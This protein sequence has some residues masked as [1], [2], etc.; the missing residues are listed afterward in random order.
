MTA[1]MGDTVTEV[2]KTNDP[3]VIKRSR[4]TFKGKF[5]RVA[6][7]LVKELMRNDEGEFLFDQIIDLQVDA[8]LSDLH[9]V[10]EIVENLHFKY[11]ITRVHK[12]GSTENQLEQEDEQYASSL[13]KIY[14]DAFKVYNAY[15]SQ[16]QVQEKLN[17]NH[18]ALEIK[19]TQYQEKLGHF[20]A[21]A[22]EY[23]SAYNEALRVVISEDEFINR[24]APLQKSLLCKEYEGL[25]S[26][27]QELLAL[28]PQVEVVNESDKK[29]LFDC[30]K[31]K[32]NHRKTLTSLESLIKKFEV[33]D[34]INLAKLSPSPFLSTE[35]SSD[36]SGGCV[37]DSN[38][39]KIKLSAPKFSGKSRDFAVFKRDFKSIVMVD[40]RSAVEIGALLK[41]SVPPHYKYLLDKFELSEHEEMMNCLTEKFGR[42][43]IIVD[44]C[45]SELKRMK[46]LT[47]D[48]EFIKFVNHLEKLKCDL[49]QLG[50]L[51]EVA[52]TTV[53]T[54][55]ESKLPY[56]VHRDWIKLVSSEDM[57]K[58]PSSE[59]L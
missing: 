11:T 13:E 33:E 27:E 47:C 31:E 21:K 12:E 54:E 6:N 7:A 2:L 41:E 9:K 4:A 3:E 22:A 52:N 14:W 45:T 35:S 16:V 55:I 56:L 20:K 19:C 15:S 10:K 40:K 18:K 51:A 59:I 53:L 48:S 57:S 8:L 58:K 36:A 5:T 1:K 44:E 37:R 25:L 32:L 50:L 23:D 42:A 30:S 46:K 38:L 24:T 29:E 43:R 39:F 49:T 28:A 26:I 17:M 34:K